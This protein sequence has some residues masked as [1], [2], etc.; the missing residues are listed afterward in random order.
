MKPSNAELE[1]S[2]TLQFGW[3]GV[4]RPRGCLA[5]EGQQ[6]N[7]T[8]RTNM[9]EEWART[10]TDPASHS[11]VQPLHPATMGITTKLR[12]L[13]NE[14]DDP[15]SGSAVARRAGGRLRHS[16]SPSRGGRP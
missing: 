2:S 8:I 10:G 5:R 15:E 3:S 1:T 11:M 7:R 12:D 14:R 4:L 6:D 9:R 16:T 13:G